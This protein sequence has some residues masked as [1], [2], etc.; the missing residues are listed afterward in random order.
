MPVYEFV[1][2]DMSWKNK[3]SNT[4]KSSYI[5]IILSIFGYSQKVEERFVKLSKNQ[6]L[7]IHQ[8]GS[9]V[10]FQCNFLNVFF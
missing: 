2:V 10:G 7:S 9:S 6:S 1:E 5:K 8:R 4:C 3:K